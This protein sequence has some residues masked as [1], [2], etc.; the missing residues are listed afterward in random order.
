[1][2]VDDGHAALH[3]SNPGGQ[4]GRCLLVPPFGVPAS[5]LTILSDLLDGHGF[6]CVRLDPRH[7]VG[8]GSGSIERFR[9]S[10][11]VADCQ[12]AIEVVDPT[13][14]VAMSLGARA[15]IRALATGPL[16]PDAVLAIPV[17]D[18][19]RTVSTIVGHDWF[20]T[21][22][23]EIPEVLE[24][25]GNDVRA[26]EFVQDSRTNDLMTAEHTERDLASV[27][28]PVLLLP[29][30]CDPWVDC[31]AVEAA[32]ERAAAR[33]R[34]VASRAIDCDRH[35]IHNDV[36]QALALIDELVDEVI[37]IHGRHLGAGEGV[38]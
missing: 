2:S 18:V 4:R 15:V 14:V 27:R 23:E 25:L 21:P 3:R 7:H 22:T 30:S 20:V 11:F 29:G 9:M 10:S 37:R 13:C 12:R 35:D 38:A 5:A 33:G 26:R 34:P 1:M 36:V 24:V 31:G 28:A 32:A 6:E 19:R 17:V 16:A 8:A